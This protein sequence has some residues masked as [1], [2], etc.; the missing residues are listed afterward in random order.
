MPLQGLSFGHLDLLG[1][2]ASL[3]H[4]GLQEAEVSICTYIIHTYMHTY[5]VRL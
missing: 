4:H 3:L 5:I 2:W 1:W